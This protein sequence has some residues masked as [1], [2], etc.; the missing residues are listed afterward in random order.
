MKS[1]CINGR[2]IGSG[3]PAYFIADIAA[4]HDGNLER[5]KELIHLARDAGADAAKFQH[6]RA[7][8]IVSREGFDTMNSKLSHQS[9]WKKSVFEVYKGAS[10]PWEWTEPLV[11]TCRKVGIDFFTSP[12]DLDMI[13]QLDPYVPAYKVGSGDITWLESIR[14]MGSKGKPVLLAAGASD[15][16]DIQ[17]A[18]SVLLDE[19]QVPT[20]LMQC[21]TNYTCSLDNF[22][23]IR[24]R[25]LNT[26]RAM[27][28][29][30]PLGLSDHT[31]GHVTVL[32]AIAL[33]ACAIEKH[34][35]DSVTR[36]GPDH[37]FSMDPRSWREMVDRSRDLEAALGDGNKQVEKNEKETSVVQRRCLRAAAD[38]PAG[39]TI[40]RSDLEVLRP[41]PA[42]S[43]PPYELPAVVGMTLAMP[44]KRGD[45]LR[46]IHLQ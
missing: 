33:G 21:N 2:E 35:T 5:A 13:D 45:V 23:F 27:Y 37:A 28:P 31:P 15:L 4:N 14:K 24:L 17:R 12:Y 22:R 43:L 30:V 16:V 29:D 26:F 40:E 46:R 32:G 44:L 19:C 41:A 11:E 39:R 3:C 1:F 6:F 34:F 10:V 7:E 25:A 42:G 38:L 9:K 18:M 8:T 20:L 36:D